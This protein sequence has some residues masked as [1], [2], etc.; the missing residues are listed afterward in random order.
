MLLELMIIPLISISPFCVLNWI[1][2]NASF[3]FLWIALKDIEVGRLGPE[4]ACFDL[5]LSV[6]V[7]GV[8]A[9]KLQFISRS[10][11]AT[12][13]GNTCVFKGKWRHRLENLIHDH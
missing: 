10:N 11:F 7:F 1:F 3:P 6:G 8:D 4:K 5:K 13:V 9:E 2:L 12:G